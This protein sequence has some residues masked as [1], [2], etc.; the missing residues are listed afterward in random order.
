VVSAGDAAAIAG[1]VESMK[2]GD[3][4]HLGQCARRFVEGLPTRVDEMRRLASVV[5]DVA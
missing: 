4:L 3:R 1:A 5:E 2:E